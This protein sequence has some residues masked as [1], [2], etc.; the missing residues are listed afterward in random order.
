MWILTYSVTSFIL[1]PFL[2]LYFQG[3]NLLELAVHL[4]E[5]A[6]QLKEKFW[7]ESRWLLLVHTPLPY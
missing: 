7:E 3:L 2:F 1:E 5:K 6:A 4:E